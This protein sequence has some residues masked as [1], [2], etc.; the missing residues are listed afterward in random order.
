MHSDKCDLDVQSSMGS[1]TLGRP[2]S[3][4]RTLRAAAKNRK[5]AGASK[6]LRMDCVLVPPR[7]PHVQ[8][9]FE[10]RNLS[11][12]EQ[13]QCLCSTGR[14][15]KEED[16]RD[17][18]P[19]RAKPSYIMPDSLV[20]ELSDYESVRDVSPVRAEI[21]ASVVPSSSDEEDSD[22]DSISPSD[23]VSVR[24]QKRRDELDKD[25]G[26]TQSD[27]RSDGGPAVCKSVSGLVGACTD[28]ISDRRLKMRATLEDI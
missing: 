25:A 13:G 14:L 28:A 26:T 21:R 6:A 20:D 24:A 22:D 7:P 8:A 12:Y 11:R 16:A 27:L 5:Q 4:P 1:I 18:S 19:S 10:Q 15:A 23:S 9:Y 17:V 3:T 2:E